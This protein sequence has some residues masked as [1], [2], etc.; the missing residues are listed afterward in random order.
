MLGFLQGFAYG[1]FLT[2][3]PWLVVGLLAPPLALPGAEPSRLQAVLRYA[4]IL[5]FVSLLLWLTSLWGGFS[6]S[7]WGWL[8]GLVA[9][10][11]ALPVERRLRAWWGRRRR[12]RLQARLD[13][14][15]TRRHEREA[16]EAHEAD[17]RHLD[18]ETPP[19]GAD[20]LV[21]ALCRA[22][23]ALE[24]KERS[25]LALQVDRF[26]SRYRRVL[27]LL[28]GSF[29]RDEVTYGRAHG[30]VSEVGREA[31]GQLEAM[32][33]LLEGVAGVDADF[34]RRRLERR[35]PRL[36]VEE[37]LALERRLALVEE[38]ER[39]L[40]RVRA[41][42]EAILTLF[43]DTCVSLARLQAEA[44]RRLGQDDALEALKRFAERAERYARKDS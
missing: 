23:A 43:D 44:P 9:I 21:R 41:R 36:G 27:A 16:R 35:E 12:A 15:L 25:D 29:R 17:L 42:L 8:A 26:Y 19:A 30:L 10:G 34:V 11:A 31:L 37:C 14:E 32:A 28:E 3:W 39:D 5:P 40:R 18:S 4:L 24:A 13:A 38:T 2:C 33:T 22:K 1:L 6:P 20:D 7:L